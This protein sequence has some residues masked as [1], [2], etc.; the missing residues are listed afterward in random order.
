MVA[1]AA[2]ADER[3]TDFVPPGSEVCPLGVGPD[4]W[5]ARPSAEAHELITGLAIQRDVVFRRE[6]FD[7]PPHPLDVSGEGLIQRCP[8]RGQPLRFLA[9][10]LFPLAP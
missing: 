4:R 5:S 10:A 3:M 1:A 8:D 9:L 6:Q 7:R 2:A